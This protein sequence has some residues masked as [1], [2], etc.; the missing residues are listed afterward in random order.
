VFTYAKTYAI[1]LETD[2]PYKT[3]KGTCKY[4]ASLGKVKIGGY[5]TTA[6]RDPNQLM[7]ALAINPVT[8]TLEADTS[9]F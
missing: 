6:A 2:Y 4:N 8:V 3:A 1:E 9:V 7:T 5:K